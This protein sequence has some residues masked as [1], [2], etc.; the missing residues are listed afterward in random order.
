VRIKLKEPFEVD[1]FIGFTGLKAS[2]LSFLQD[3]IASCLYVY[4]VIPRHKSLLEH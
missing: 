4:N 1:S 2:D 3:R